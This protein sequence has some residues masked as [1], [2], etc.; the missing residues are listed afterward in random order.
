M[1]SDTVG[2][3]NSGPEHHAAKE[4]NKKEGEEVDEEEDL[5]DIGAND[6]KQEEY[7]FQIAVSM[8]VTKIMDIDEY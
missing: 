7:D 8:T 6:F 5:D 2:V 1:Q 4:E 3:N